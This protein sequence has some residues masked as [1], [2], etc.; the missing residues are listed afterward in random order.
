MLRGINVSGHKVIRM[1]DLRQS[2]A[3]LGF[4]NLQT[5]VQSGN[6]VFLAP[7]QPPAALSQRISQTILKDFG[8]H[9]PVVVRTSK[10]MGEVIQGNPFLQE[11]G[12][13]I[14]RLHVTFLSDPAPASARKNLQALSANPDR[15][16]LA[17]R[18]IYLHCP[19]GYGRSK[20]SNT[21]IEKALS[22]GATTRNWKT[23]TTLFAMA[24]SL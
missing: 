5:Y 12:I 8:F 4:Q 10:E 2:C 7:A 15:F 18:H 22:L 23:V 14:S 1:E 6:I 20:L 21:A 11:K 13:D 3:A 16:H 24:S 19:D 9:V 17:R